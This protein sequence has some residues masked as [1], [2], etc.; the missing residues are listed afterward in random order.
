MKSNN[1]CHHTAIF[2]DLFSVLPNRYIF[3][4][5]ADV[6]AIGGPIPN[7]ATTGAGAIVGSAAIVTFLVFCKRPLAVDFEPVSVVGA[8]PASSLHHS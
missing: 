6:A 3:A 7:G 5:L 2:T 4:A 1:Y 8:A